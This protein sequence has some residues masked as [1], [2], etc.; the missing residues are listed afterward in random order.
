MGA[1]LPRPPGPLD[2]TPRPP[3]G[4]ARLSPT[5]ETVMARPRARPP[6]PQPTQQPME[7]VGGVDA[8][9]ASGVPRQP[10]RLPP[11]L[12]AAVTPERTRAVTAVPFLLD[13]P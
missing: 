2:G 6:I 3:L 1:T 4:E 7:D 8:T 5:V 13:A 11:R 10:P 12:A 9:P